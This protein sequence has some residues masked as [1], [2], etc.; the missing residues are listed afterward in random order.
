[1][2]FYR[3]QNFNL[4]LQKNFVCGF[5]LKFWTST[6]DNNDSFYAVIDLLTPIHESRKKSKNRDYPGGHPWKKSQ[7]KFLP[8]MTSRAENIYD[9]GRIPLAVLI[10]D[11]KI[12]NLRCMT[13]LESSQWKKV[14]DFFPKWRS[15]IFAKC[16]R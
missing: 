10:Y 6:I 9:I 15:W 11:N 14:L 4:R 8:I 2:Y 5:I 13:S 3:S 1:M 7:R 12:S 16:S